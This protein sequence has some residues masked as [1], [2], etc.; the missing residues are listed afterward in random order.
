MIAGLVEISLP[1][2]PAGARGVVLGLRTASSSASFSFSS[3]ASLTLNFCPKVSIRKPSHSRTCSGINLHFGNP[4][5]APSAPIRIAEIP[6]CL[7]HLPKVSAAVNAS[8][9]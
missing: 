8:S 2:S 9:K 4:R 1:A 5:K 6:L 3:F 7:A